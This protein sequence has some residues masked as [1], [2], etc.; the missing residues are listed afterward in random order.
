[1]AYSARVSVVLLGTVA[2][3]FNGACLAVGIGDAEA[4][5]RR[6]DYVS[7]VPIYQTLAE[8]GDSN[9]M[10]RLAG[11]LQKGEGV[12]KN[13]AR[14]IALY[15]QAAAQ[16]NP[17]AQY[18]LGN[19]YL[20]GEG[21][22]QD[23]DWAFTYYRQA[24]AQGH[25]LAKKNVDEFYRAAGVTPPTSVSAAPVSGPPPAATSNT[26]EYERMVPDDYS[27]DEL[28]AIE[29]ARAQGIQVDLAGLDDA[30]ST[31]APLVP[32]LSSTRLTL[33][34]VRNSLANGDTDLALSDLEILASNGDPEAQ[35]MLSGLLREVRPSSEADEEALLWL[36]RSA[37]GGNADAQ[38]KL[39]GYYHQGEFV[40]LDEAEAVTWYRAAARQGHVGAREILDSI[41]RDAGVNVPPS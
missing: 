23:D 35:Y 25:P 19:L 11:L 13:L 4:A 39:A 12:P 32:E 18:S 21:V 36:K 37:T 33:E 15:T 28:N 26:S 20:M 34:S 24:A 40:P 5:L 17:G 16:N 38:F 30:P 31:A 2:M 1:M 7:A 22:P 9:A 3:L 6:G 14:A 27:T 10:V 29:A 41:Y 8:A